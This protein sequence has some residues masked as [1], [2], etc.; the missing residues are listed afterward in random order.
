MTF[1]ES[2]S[3]DV[4]ES[5]PTPLSRAQEASQVFT[6]RGVKFDVAVAGIPFILAANDGQPY[7]RETAQFQKQQIDTS[8]DAGEQT[9]DGYWIR[10]Q[11]S[12]HMG[13]GI[14][15]YEPSTVPES[16]NRFEESQ[17]ID[18]WTEGKFSLLKA[19]SS[20]ATVSGGQKA[21]VT[22]AVV[23]GLD[24][25]FTNENG[26]IKRRNTSTTSYTGVTDGLTKV[27]LAGSKILVGRT[28]SIAVGDAT[29]SSLADLWTGAASAPT[30]YWAKSR[31][32]AVV[33]ASLWDL[34]L[35]GGAWPATALHTHPD[36]GWKWT[37]VAE[38]PSAIY[39]AGYS[40]GVSSIYR[41][42]LGD[43][44]TGTVPELGQA[45]QVAELPPGE[46]IHSIH[47]ALGTFLG[48]GTTK[49]FRVAAILD[50]GSLSMGPILFDTTKPVEA[51]T[52]GDR[53]FYGVIEAGQPDGKSG[54]FRVDLSQQVGQ[55]NTLRFPWAWD[56][57]S[58]QTAAIGSI[59]LYGVSDRVALGIPGVGIQLQSATVYEAEGYVTS[60]RIR[61]GTVIP[62]AF[63][64]FSVTS[65]NG[66]GSIKVYAVEA[67]DSELYL[68]TL[69][70]GASGLDI[71]MAST[72]VREF[73]R[74]KLV[75][76]PSVDT[77]ESPV[78]ES[79]QVRALPAPSRQRMV[80]FPLLC[81][82]HEQTADG[83]KIGAE[84]YAIQRLKALEYAE[85]NYVVVTVQDFN[86]DETFQAQIEQVSFRRPGPRSTDGRTNFGG[87]INLTVRKL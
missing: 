15:F 70:N 27:A 29:G 11:T 17:G 34:T 84:G 3:P 51:I 26:T 71:S 66:S 62:K 45:Y 2:T 57:R 7:Q 76:E 38:G 78:V 16:E 31:I 19:M 46:E 75:V 53:F 47:A 61:Y 55:G 10:S 82:D 33:G 79:I 1:S 18:V 48:I 85:E 49:G 58:A 24:T 32:I 12:W 86:T 87:F 42:N 59:A 39:A 6:Q 52:S 43:A 13:A 30:P 72:Q 56:A 20:L 22:G 14:R 73:Y 36:S 25:L 63:R 21:F 69:A 40:N 41:F 81:V 5:L 64:L 67:N 77:L 60:G 68:R 4:T 44:G 50:D 8:R 83:V 74:F 35:A 9:L 54:A 23:G 28:T 80:L 37:G 65:S